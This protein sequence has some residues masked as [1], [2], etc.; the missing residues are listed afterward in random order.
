M[1]ERHWLDTP[2]ARSARRRR[3]ALPDHL[4]LPLAYVEG[5]AELQRVS[6]ADFK[7]KS[8]AIMR[9]YDGAVA[10]LGLPVVQLRCDPNWRPL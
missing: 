5:I 8:E 9:Y 3:V 4:V 10:A 6:F 1:K 7:L 2:L